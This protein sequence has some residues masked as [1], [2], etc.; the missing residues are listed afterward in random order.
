MVAASAASAGCGPDYRRPVRRSEQ[1]RNQD[2]IIVADLDGALVLVLA[3]QT[4][5]DGMSFK[6]LV[7]L[8]TQSASFTTMDNDDPPSPAR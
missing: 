6:A 4:R 8:W 2:E 3:Q 5:N 1:E 7:L